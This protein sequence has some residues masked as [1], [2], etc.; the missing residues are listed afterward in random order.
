MERRPGLAESPLEVFP[1]VR[2][3]VPLHTT[4]SFGL[5]GPAE[6]LATPRSVTELATLVR[7]CHELGV[8]VRMLGGGTNLLV[9][10][11]GVGGMVVRL[12]APAFT[13]IEISGTRVVA[14]VGA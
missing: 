2:K 1:C 14:G 6:Y 7:R 13:R 4:T 5:G 8:P 11:E 9:A 10:D 12:S 3:H